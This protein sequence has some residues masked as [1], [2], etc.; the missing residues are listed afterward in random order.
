MRKIALLLILS[1]CFIGC[2]KESS[3]TIVGVWALTEWN[4]TLNGHTSYNPLS[5]NDIKTWEFLE[6]G[7]GYENGMNPFEYRMDEKTIYMNYLQMKVSRNM[8]I[9]VLSPSKLQVHWQEEHPE[10]EF[11]IVF[12]FTRME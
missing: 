8:D 10:G 3:P 2:Q 1:F 6:N 11:H 9:Q 7:K 5:W 4:T 12:S